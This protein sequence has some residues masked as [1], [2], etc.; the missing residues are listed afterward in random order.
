MEKLFNNENFIFQ[1]RA[2]GEGFDF[3]ENPIVQSNNLTDP[4]KV[5]KINKVKL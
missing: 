5:I 3:Q 2:G 1:L 4:T